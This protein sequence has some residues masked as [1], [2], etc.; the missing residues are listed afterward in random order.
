MGQKPSLVV[1]VEI[2]APVD[3]VKS[4]FKDF[5]RFREWSSWSIDPAVSSKKYDDLI[6]EEKLSVDIEGFKFTAT[7]L[8]NDPDL[9]EWAGGLWP[10][11]LGEHEFFWRAST[12]TPGGTTFV[13]R[14]S[15]RG[16]MAFLWQRDWIMGRKTFKSFSL[17]NSEIKKE[18]E[19]RAA[20]NSES[21]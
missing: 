5:S 15:W 6:P 18:A 19:R 11:L 7:L 9:F 8:K 13:Q 20:A 1:E 12:K 4:V 2:Q 17:F 10:L 3:V 16:L 14:E 21:S